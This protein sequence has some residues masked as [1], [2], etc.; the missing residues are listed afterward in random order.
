MTQQ[1]ISKYSNL[2]TG[3]NP[4]G[5]FR[6]DLD[7]K[8]THSLHFSNILKMLRYKEVELKYA[9]I[10]RIFISGSSSAG[11]THFAHELLK[12]NLFDMKMIYYFH[13][14]SV[15]VQPVDWDYENIVFV[16]G[17]PSLEDLLAIPSQSCLIF[18]D[19]YDEC[20]NSRQVD[21][22]YRV[23]SGKN[24]LHCMIMTQRYFAQGRY[25]L[26]IRNSSNYHVL[27]RNA[28]EHTNTRVADKMKLKVEVQKANELNENKL[29]PYIFIDVNNF[30]R[31]NGVRVYIDIFSK[32]KKVILKSEVY[33]LIPER[34]FK[35]D[36]TKIDNIHAVRNAT[37]IKQSPTETPNSRSDPETGPK[38]EVS[39]REA[40][41][42]K[43]QAQHHL[44]RSIRKIVHRYKKRSVI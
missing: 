1:I 42:A 5:I 40:S 39:K 32:F 21:Y 34:D 24:H 41:R 10:F 15:N 16:A 23:L 22:L 38:T 8:K 27:M 30:S 6:S 12:L 29:Y 44:E 31:L 33:V 35:S 36:F 20:C 17:L 19:L 4:I 7:Y 43:R 9:D 14:D 2:K 11:K 28:D 3:L 18:D 37:S 13:P 25:A 26:N